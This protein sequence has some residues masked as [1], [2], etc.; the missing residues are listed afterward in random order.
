MPEPG[1]YLEVHHHTGV[2]YLPLVFS[3]GWQTAILNW[4]PPI[5]RANLGEIERHTRTDEVFVLWR[6][7]AALF[8]RAENQI[9]LVDMQPGAVYNVTAGT[10]HSLVASRDVS[11]V[12]VENRDTHLCD[13]EIRCLDSQEIAQLVAQLPEWTAQATAQASAPE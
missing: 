1:K 6:G 12:I 8:V 2:G 9:E 3:G 4:E 11:L 7:Q 10:W 13:T 5:D